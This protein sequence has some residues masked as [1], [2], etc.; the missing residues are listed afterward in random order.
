MKEFTGILLYILH[1]LVVL[2]NV[3]AIPFI[4][5]FVKSDDDKLKYLKF[6]IIFNLIILIQWFLLDGECCLSL[7]QYYCESKPALGPNSCVNK[8]P[9]VF[10][11]G[12]TI[13]TLIAILI[14]HKIELSNK[15]N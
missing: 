2:F 9:V 6:Y 15:K 4:C 3:F 8:N 11:I 14:R 10:W 12:G 1:I 13:L 7:I 5:I